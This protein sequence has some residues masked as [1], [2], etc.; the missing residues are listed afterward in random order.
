[1]SVIRIVTLLAISLLVAPASLQ[2]QV[3][4]QDYQKIVPAQESGTPGKIEVIEFFSY[5]CPHC[6]EMEPLITQWAAALPSNVVLVKVPVS[7]GRREWGQLSRAYYALE[8]LGAV[9]RLSAALF[10]AIHRGKQPLFDEDHLASWVGQHG[11]D[12]NKFRAEF[13]SFNVTTKASRAEQL[14]RN[15]KVQ[16]VPY[17][18]V[19]GKYGA[20]GKTYENMLK[21]ARQLV[22]RSA[23][24]KQA[25]NH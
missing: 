4:N 22:D 15:Y 18:T 21:T 3:E 2:A 6:A 24:E 13:N 8:S 10:D 20:L 25:A 9:P 5:G 19:D 7:F 16:G 14:S 23:S 12:A 17:I 11:V 1:M